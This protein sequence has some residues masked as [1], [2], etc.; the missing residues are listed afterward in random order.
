MFWNFDPTDVPSIRILAPEPEPYSPRERLRRA[1]SKMCLYTGSRDRLSS[2]YN[3]PK[4]NSLDQIVWEVMDR[5]KGEKIQQDPEHRQ[6]LG[7][8]SVPPIQN[9]NPST[10][11]LPC[12]SYPKEETQGDMCHAHAL[13]RPGPQYHINSTQVR[14]QLWVLQDINE[15]PR[16]AENESPWE[17]KS[18][19]RKNLFQRVPVDKNIKSL[20]LPTIQQKQNQGQARHELTN[21]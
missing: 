15:K 19:A 6:A 12:V 3:N 14:R 5:V 2:S 7:E 16:S 4:K 13:A 10:S 21:L 1:I 18:K 8:E 17:R 20:N 11:S 9:T